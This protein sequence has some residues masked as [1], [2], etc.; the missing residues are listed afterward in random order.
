[1]D[2][3]LAAAPGSKMLQIEKIILEEVKDDEKVLVFAAFAGIKSEVYTQLLGRVGDSVGVYTTDGGDQDSQIIDSFKNHPGKAVLVQSLMSSESAGTNLTEASHVV[4]AGA[5]FTDSD[6]YTMY[7]NQAKG[8]VIR[9][10][11]ARKVTIYHLVS[12]G[13]LEFDIF[14]QR[15]GGRIRDWGRHA[16]GRIRLPIPDEARV[17]PAYP[18]RY[19]PYLE[20]SAVEKLL[21]SVEFEEFEG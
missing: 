17:D 8:R 13:T 19:R 11:Q 10:G 7:M 6:N 18:L 3:N 1:M 4:F 20:D 21:R 12:P 16:Y 15:Q 2:A 14:N 9:Q 5:L